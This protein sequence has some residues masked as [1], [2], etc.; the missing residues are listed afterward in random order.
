MRKILPTPPSIMNDELEKIIESKG[1]LFV[2]DSEHTINTIQ[3]FET[4][5]S[6]FDRL[7]LEAEQ[8]LYKDKPRKISYGI[9]ANTNFNAFAYASS[10]EEEK[11]FDFVGINIGTIFTLLDIFGRIL[12]H[13]DNLTNV[14]N[15]SLEKAERTYISY[16]ST[17]VMKTQS[18]SCIPNCHIRNSYSTNL[19]ITALKFL[20]YHE[21]THLRNGHLEFIKEE[22]NYSYYQEAMDTGR[23][24]LDP[25]IHQ[26]LEM[27][28]DSGAILKV[29]NES[30]KLMNL[31]PR[32]GVDLNIL[33]VFN[34]SYLDIRISTKTVVFSTYILF[35]L[36][37]FIEWNYFNQ[38]KETHPQPPIRMFWLSCTIYE[39]FR[40]RPEYNY[41]ADTFISDATKIMLEAEITLGKIKNEEPDTRG[42]QSVVSTNLHL[43]YLNEVK[44]AWKD[45]RPQLENYKRGG[46]L[47]D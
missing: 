31:S 45:I 27:D 17:D 1:G 8:E 13:P 34:Y 22:L 6:I 44:K 20:F 12:S 5:N 7:I 14:G 18:M 41:N 9:I 2:L 11:P 32:D 38:D 33:A 25:V 43:E 3:I 29:L 4:I 21:I 19:M 24:R 40:I 16:L 39:I 47:A 35:R 46:N 42:I 30:F 26:A 15:S 10:Q 23:K 28:A 37:D 36:F